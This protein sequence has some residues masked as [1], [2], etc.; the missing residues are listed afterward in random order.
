M[1]SN[2]LT[3]LFF[4]TLCLGWNAT[5]SPPDDKIQF[6]TLKDCNDAM[7]KNCS[8]RQSLGEGTKLRI[9]SADRS[10]S[11]RVEAKDSETRGIET[12]EEC[13]DCTLYEF[14]G[15]KGIE[16]CPRDN[17]YVIGAY[18]TYGAE[19]KEL[20]NYKLLKMGKTTQPA[21]LKAARSAVDSKL[22][23]PSKADSSQVKEVLEY[24]APQF[25]YQFVH[26][27]NAGPLD[28]GA[29]LIMQEGSSPKLYENG[30]W[31]RGYLIPFQLG[32]RYFLAIEEED[33]LSAE[34]YTIFEMSKSGMKCV[35]PTEN[36][37]KLK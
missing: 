1:K 34:L 11:C 32:E 24:P 23:K 6:V 16:K 29:Y 28:R 10:I 4:T 17:T 19:V 15:I 26:L 8:I 37:T 14:T 27:E 5:A 3:A 22:K 36:C 25:K 7:R 2:I 13:S 31:L 18:G 20:E 21:I 33:D 35:F 12:S 9:F 30:L